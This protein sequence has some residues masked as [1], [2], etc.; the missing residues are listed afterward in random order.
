VSPPPIPQPQVVRRHSPASLQRPSPLPELLTQFAPLTAVLTLVER[1]APTDAPVMIIGEPGTGKT[2]LARAIHAASRRAGALVEVDASA[3]PTDLLDIEL[4]GY[5]GGG[6]V[7]G[8]KKPGALE[9][10]AHGTVL[11]DEI[12]A[13][14][15]GAQAK[16]LSALGKGFFSRPGGKRRVELS[17]RV[18]SATA[19][20]IA[21]MVRDGRFN[22][23]LFQGLRTAHVE[24]PPLRDRRTD[25]P[26][27]A[28]QFAAQFG[29]LRAPRL[30][31]EAIGVLEGHDWPGNV[32]EL[33][34]V[35]ERA[36]MAANGAEIQ[37]RDLTFLVS[38]GATGIGA[39]L[40]LVELERRHIQAV[41]QQTQWHQGR[42]AALLG[43]S[44]KTLYRKIREYGFERP[45]SA[46]D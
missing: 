10:A 32:R 13:L 37:A 7:A 39:P 38:H 34:N 44:C 33:R 24:L 31:P 16:L 43:I 28:Q 21:T 41:L 20:P 25:I 6:S 30:T 22:D 36:V 2:L 45:S 26:F 8:G 19:H 17:A 9:L 1:V 27:L 46:R 4:F 29:G 23:D 15:H 3:L 12:A 5:E 14:G 18:I 42:A 40:R 11:I 35:V